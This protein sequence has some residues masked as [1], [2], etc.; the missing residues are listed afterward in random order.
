MKK[1]LSFLLICLAS[2]AF[3]SCDMLN[4]G[5]PNEPN[6]PNNPNQPSDPN[7]TLYEGTVILNAE[8]GS[9]ARKLVVA[10]ADW[11][12]NNKY[13]WYTLSSLY[14][15]AGESELTIRA[16]Q[17]NEDI[18]ERVGY[19]EING[20]RT[21]VI[22]R[23]QIVIEPVKSQILVSPGETE[24]YINFEG[25]FPCEEFQ[26]TSDAD[27]AVYD[28]TELTEPRVVFEDGVTESNYNESA[29]VVKIAGDNTD[30]TNRKANIT[31]VAGEKTMTITLVQLGTSVGEVDFSKEF[32]RGNLI[33]KFTGTWCGWCPSLAIP[34]HEVQE[35]NPDRLFIV[36]L[37]QGSGSL[38]WD[39]GYR[40]IE[41][42]F[43]VGGYP[44]GYLNV[45][46]EELT[47][48]DAADIEQDMYDFMEEYPSTVGI[49]AT[50]EVSNGTAKITVKLAAK[51][52]KDYKINAFF[53]EDGIIAA[54]SNYVEE[55]NS[56][57][58]FAN[59]VHDDILRGSA[60]TG[61]AAGGEDIELNIGE[62]TTEEF[63]AEVPSDIEDV[64]NAHVI[65]FVTYFVDDRDFVVDNVIDIPLVGGSIDFK[66]EE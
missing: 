59:Y 26:V 61:Y 9:I 60:T 64:N 65:I 43:G 18:M 55:Y 24:V 32:L 13:S 2:V 48:R 10:D 29:V 66:Y 38:T 40:D 58:D 49:A 53:M 11:V 56:Y 4:N 20:D 52:S 22:Q 31:V 35:D 51:D 8:A 42:Y 36:N 27:W 33:F 34:C 1:V 62:V 16:N 30:A 63:V 5:D 37:Y 57:I 17:P 46:Y 25:T 50:S 21:Y 6:N 7:G 14:G 23:G 45:N 19:F 39:E 54:Q 41:N 15:T 47:S 3:V 12:V 28:R 44:M